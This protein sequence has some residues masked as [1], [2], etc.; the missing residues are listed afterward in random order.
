[1]A[2][3]GILIQNRLAIYATL[4]GDNQPAASFMAY[5]DMFLIMAV[6]VLMTTIPALWLRQQR[7]G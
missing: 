6:L 2:F 4:L 5:H 1:V 3:A 7:G